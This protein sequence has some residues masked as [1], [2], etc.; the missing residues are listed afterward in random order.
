MKLKV[1]IRLLCLLDLNYTSMQILGLIAI[2]NS[3]Q[4]RMIRRINELP[5]L[6]SCLHCSIS[7][8]LPTVFTHSIQTTTSLPVRS[9]YTEDTHLVNTCS[10]SNKM[11]TIEHLIRTSIF[12]LSLT[13]RHLSLSN[14]PPPY[15]NNIFVSVDCYQC[16]SFRR[17]DYICHHTSQ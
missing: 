11:V 10:L 14:L 17:I 7:S 9:Y 4:D 16:K 15:F 13:V 2:T 6:H 8:R 5:W 3:N 1:L 12:V